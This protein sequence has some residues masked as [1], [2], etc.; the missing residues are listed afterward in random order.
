[1]SSDVDLVLAARHKRRVRG[2][3]EIAIGLAAIIAGIVITVVTYSKAVKGGG[4]YLIAYGPVVVGFAATFDVLWT[5]DVFAGAAV[6]VAAIA[7]AAMT[8]S[9][10]AEAITRFMGNGLRE[11][12]SRLSGPANYELRHLRRVSVE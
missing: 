6:V 4:T 2:V 5:L 9:A 12:S 3:I 7:G 1:M 11:N 8:L 10:I